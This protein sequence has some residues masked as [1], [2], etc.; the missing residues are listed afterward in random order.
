VAGWRAPLPYKDYYGHLAQFF[1][2]QLAVKVI[3]LQ[4]VADYYGR[5]THF[6]F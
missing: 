2:F 3:T 6:K 5:L 1:N 4:P